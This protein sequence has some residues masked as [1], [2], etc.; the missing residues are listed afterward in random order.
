MCL[1]AQVDGAEREVKRQSDTL[2]PLMEMSVPKRKNKQNSRVLRGQ[3]RFLI[4][5]QW[6]SERSSPP[7]TEYSNVEEDC[8]VGG[9]GAGEVSLFTSCEG[10]TNT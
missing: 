10:N 4:H 9:L 2:F 5:H 7:F 8:P 6:G 1:T 3:N